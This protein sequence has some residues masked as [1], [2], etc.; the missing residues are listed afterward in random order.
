MEYYS[1]T[2]RGGAPA[3]CSARAEAPGH[4][5]REARATPPSVRSR[6]RGASTEAGAGLTAAARAME[7][8]DG[9]WEGP[10]TAAGL[11]GEV[12]MFW[13]EVLVTVHVFVHTANH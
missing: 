10:L 6:Q 7:N 4:P 2:K 12:D 11:P 1:A 3:L 5:V 9:E 13:N 8:G